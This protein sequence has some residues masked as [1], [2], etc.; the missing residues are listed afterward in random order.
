MK[1]L[2]Y[3]SCVLLILHSLQ[4]KGQK[5]ETSKA[6]T[7]QVTAIYDSIIVKA[8][9]AFG[10]EDYD[11]ASFYYRQ[12][13]DLKPSDTYATKM[14]KTVEVNKWQFADRQAKRQDLQRKALINTL[15]K[16]ASTAIMDKNYDS[17]RA[18]YS[19]VLSLNPVASQREFAQQKIQAIDQATGTAAK[20]FP[21][22]EVETGSN[23]SK[24][25]QE[26]VAHPAPAISAPSAANTN[27]SA[28][29]QNTAIKKD[30]NIISAATPP[31]ADTATTHTSASAS[32][33]NAQKSPAIVSGTQPKSGDTGSTHASN[34]IVT[35]EQNATSTAIKTADPTSK[36]KSDSLVAASNKFKP[37]TSAADFS[38]TGAKP[39][40]TEIDRLLDDALTATLNGN[41]EGARIVYY[42]VLISGASKQQKDF[43]KKKIDEINVQLKKAKVVDS[44]QIASAGDRER[45]TAA[46]EHV[47]KKTELKEE[48]KQT[49]P[50][51]K[52]ET[53]LTPKD[54]KP[55]VRSGV[56]KDAVT[57]NAGDLIST[58]S[59]RMNDYQG[60][61]TPGNLDNENS[62]LN[63]E[64]IKMF[65][66]QPAKLN[67]ADSS[68]DVK[69]TC[70]GVA[71]SGRN[72]F[73]K[74]LI[75]NESS[76]PFN[77]GSLQ[78]V[79]LQNYG[80]LKKLSPHYISS[81]P[82]ILPGKEYPV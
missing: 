24:I 6:T 56:A 10:R 55:V 61:Q 46:T 81:T 32:N 43:A 52:K 9:L 45:K 71:F 22:K 35:T 67:I 41:Y 73:I 33:A 12:A 13:M 26:K 20:S 80:I 74:F 44:T 77:L 38:K 37:A 63:K 28:S 23:R 19:R 59:T 25:A 79:Y 27:A 3:V 42:Q 39:A 40:K 78:L 11:S 34:A 30:Q 14:L 53:F 68:N 31:K 5:V 21:Q 8:G 48:P 15:M 65:I 82:A 18:R 2:K 51:A 60:N 75:L 50:V 36:V 1:L 58:S 57:P 70:Q 72:V 7:E 54:N 17:A 29:V 47:A 16:D 4:S 66:S 64:F 76:T 49:V 62:N 69:L